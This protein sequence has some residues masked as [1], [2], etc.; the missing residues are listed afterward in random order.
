M[1]VS[2][3]LVF[4]L[5]DQSYALCLDAVE[6]VL[7]AVYLTSVPEAPEMLSGV[8]NMGGRIVPVLDIRKRFNL[9]SRRIELDDR[10]IVSKGISRRLAIIVDR[11][12]GVDAF[13]PDDMRDG[14]KI[15]ADVEGRVAGIGISRDNTVLIYDLNTLFSVQDIDSLNTDADPHI[16]G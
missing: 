15:L 10:I 5:D 2:H 13:E 1:A 16:E 4:R 12:E 3:Y 6:R 11:V 7:R 8:I 9:P 14:E